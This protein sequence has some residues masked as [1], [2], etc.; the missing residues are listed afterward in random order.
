MLLFLL[1]FS[2]VIA[3]FF[4]FFSYCDSFLSWLIL[5]NLDYS[6]I[7]SNYLSITGNAPKSLV[8]ST[9]GFGSDCFKVTKLH[10]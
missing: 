5:I 1:K 7:M 9:K 8:V 3:F 4:F 2:L 10:N 6:L